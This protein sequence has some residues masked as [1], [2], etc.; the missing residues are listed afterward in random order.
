[1]RKEHWTWS[2]TGLDVMPSSAISKLS[3]L[4]QAVSPQW[5]RL[6]G[7]ANEIMCIQAQHIAGAQLDQNLKSREDSS[8]RSKFGDPR[9]RRHRARGLALDIE[10]GCG[11]LWEQGSK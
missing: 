2:Q 9:K 8:R 1:M 11:Q 6:S 4:G 7:I 5:I 10:I 3:G